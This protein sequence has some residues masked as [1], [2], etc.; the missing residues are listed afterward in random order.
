RGGAGGAAGGARARRRGRGRPGGAAR[1]VS[2]VRLRRGVARSADAAAD[3]GDA[4]ALV[5]RG[6]R[7]D[8][9]AAARALGDAMKPAR[10]GRLLWLALALV[11]A[12]PAAADSVVYRPRSRLAEELL[13]LADA[14]LAGEGRAV[15][16]PG[17]NSLVLLGPRPALD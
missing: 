5:V 12:R 14:A 16:D 3:R 7:G 17:T 1:E 6:A 15:V 9:D 10:A 11:L 4:R 8:R 2:A 13:P